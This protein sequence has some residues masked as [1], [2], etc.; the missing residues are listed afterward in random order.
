MAAASACT[1]KLRCSNA[2]S[3]PTVTSLLPTAPVLSS[4]WVAVEATL[5]SFWKLVS[6]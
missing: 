5:T 6:A 3:P 2:A 1:S 4:D